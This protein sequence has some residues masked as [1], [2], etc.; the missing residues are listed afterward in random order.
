MANIAVLSYNKDKFSE[1]F[2]ANQ[3]K[4]LAGNIHYLYGGALAQC[5]GNDSYFIPQ[6]TLQHIKYSVK[7]VLGFGTIH[8]QHIS[9]VE[10][11]LIDNKIEAVLANYANTALSLMEICYKNNIPLVV[12]FH[13]WTAYRKSFLDQYGQQYPRLFEIAKAIVAVSQ[14]MKTQLVALGANAD[15]ITVAPCG[16]DENLFSFSKHSNNDKLFLLAGRLCDT[17]NPHLS[18]LAFSEATKE[19]QDAKLII[20]GGDEGLLNACISLANGLG[21]ENKIEYR[22]VLSHSEMKA[23]MAKSFA[24]LQHSATTIE[25]EKEGTPVTLLEAALSGLPIIATKHAGIGEVFRHN[26]SALLCNE[27][28]VSA[29]AKNIEYLLHNKEVYETLASNAYT[30]VKESY[31]LKQYIYTLNEVLQKSIH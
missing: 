17:K 31:T 10:K 28:D 1:T 25:G 30:T 16:A 9:A 26:H 3:V 13:G 21:I 14:D 12:H 5:Y 4:H 11:Y 29:M 22:G 6:G 24:I 2:I 8:Q 15:K 7:E 19:I 27:F 18:M 20:A 23:L